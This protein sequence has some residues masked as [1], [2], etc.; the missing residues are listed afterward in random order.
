MNQI[1]HWLP[2]VREHKIAKA[3]AVADY[4]RQHFFSKEFFDLVIN[5]LKINLNS[6]FT[7]LELGDNYTHWITRWKELMTHPKVIEY[8]NNNQDSRDPTKTQ[9]DFIMT[10]A[11]NKLIEKNP[12]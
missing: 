8:L 2:H 7:E 4:N 6:A 12:L 10:L 1:R 3:Q 11:Q 5:E 9:V